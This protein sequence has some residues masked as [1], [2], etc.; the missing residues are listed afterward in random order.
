MIQYTAKE[1]HTLIKGKDEIAE[2]LAEADNT[3]NKARLTLT[4]NYKLDRVTQ[5]DLVVNDLINI[6]IIFI[7]QNTNIGRGGL[8]GAFDVLL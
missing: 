1:T 4:Q 8:H 7:Y 5:T 2:I 6:K 3:P